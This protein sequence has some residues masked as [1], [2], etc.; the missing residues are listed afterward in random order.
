MEQQTITRA[1]KRLRHHLW[2]AFGTFALTA[3]IY[4]VLMLV[5]PSPR[6][7]IFRWSLATAYVASALLAFTLTLGAWN[8]WRGKITPISS[9]L[10][11]DFGIWCGIWAIA[12]TFIGL[13][14][15]QKDWRHY[16]FD[17]DGAWRTD[18][19][20][21]VNYVGVAAVLIVIILLLTSNDFAL[22]KL[23]SKR[24]KIIQRLNYVFAFLVALHGI[25]FIVVE[26]RIVP[27]LFIFGAFV[28]WMLVFQI[29]GF[30]KRRRELVKES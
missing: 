14:V 20:G 4:A 8:L 22:K 18:L 17:D 12:H 27:F 13:N 28:V 5:Y 26:K 10:R 25:L 16:F 9:D 7:W 19:F 3:A 30:Q 6:L 1:R 29:I 24:W 11:R 15:H 21:F 23:K 2:L